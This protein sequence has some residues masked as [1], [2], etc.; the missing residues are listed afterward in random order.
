[1]YSKES[2]EPIMEPWGT[3]ALTGYSYNDLASR[4]TITRLLL[5]NDK[6]KSKIRL[7]NPEDLSL[8]KIATCQILSKALEYLVD[9]AVL[10]IIA[11]LSETAARGSAFEWGIES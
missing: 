7:K 11:I 10:K 5:K 6:M 8:R 4:T 2:L 1:M 3:P 9:V